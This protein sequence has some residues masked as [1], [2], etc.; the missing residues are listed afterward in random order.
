MIVPSLQRERAVVLGVLL[1]VTALAWGYLL[2]GAGMEAPQ[3]MSM[4]GQ[5][6]LMAPVWTAGYGAV[7]FLMW[8]GMMVAMMLP[9]A[10][11]T[12]LLAAA[13]MRERGAH[14]A[15]MRTALFAAGY[16]AV[17]LGFS[18]LCA[19]AQW[20]LSH[21]G[22]LSDTMAS[23]S[24][25]LSGLLLIGAGLYQW[26]PAKQACLVRCRSPVAQLTRFWRHGAAGPMLAG[27]C[28]GAYCLGCCWLLMGLLFVGG[29]MN[30]SWVA[31]LAV[32]VLIEKV[33]PRGALISRVAGL[34]L[35]AWGAF[36]LVH[37]S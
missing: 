23:N 22:M 26:A 11:P 1:A 10:A 18:L 19:F 27:L 29:V 24:R 31:L 17:W 15:W 7:V 5:L 4:G 25:L 3:K 2:S 34:G 9:G 12:V 13:V 30:L 37:R 21:I 32:F 28:N 33:S 16:I 20:G 6:M 35:V 8:A 14:R 36:V